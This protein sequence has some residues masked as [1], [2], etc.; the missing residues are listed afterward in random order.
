[1]YSQIAIIGFCIYM[2][3]FGLLLIVR[4]SVAEG[5]GLKILT[6]AGRTEIRVFYGG[7]SL[8]NGLFFSLLFS[9]GLIEECLLGA[10]LTAAT[11][12][13][14]RI[15]GTAVDGGWQEGYTKLA[16]PCETLFVIALAAGLLSI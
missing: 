14:I 11:I 6:P 7:I 15:L 2:L 12:L 4:P 13:T 5:F 9:R 10:T 16:I 1:M 3:G 8:A